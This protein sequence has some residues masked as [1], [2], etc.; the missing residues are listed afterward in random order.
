MSARRI[1]G[2]AIVS[3][4]GM[5]A[6]AEGVMPDTLKFEADAR[7]FERGMDGVDVAAHGRHSHEGQAHSAQRQRLI[8]TRQVA[9]IGPDPSNDMA[10]LWNPAGASLDEALAALGQPEAAVGVVGGTDV[11]G[12]FL[13]RYDVFYLT[14]GPKVR[15][16]G[17]RPVF[18]QVPRLTPEQ[19][20]AE[21]GYAEGPRE[22]LDAANG[23]EVVAWRRP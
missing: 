15:L 19:V 9:G 7:F 16:P 4:D 10:R 14:R 1:E 5:L 11:F 21:H 18:P 3:E 6:N 17:G 20:L 13:D 8:V 22:V 12:L 23:I 2:F